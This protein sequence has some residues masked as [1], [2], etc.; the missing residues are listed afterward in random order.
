MKAL[1]F[2][3]TSVEDKDFLREIQ[4]LGDQFFIDFHDFLVEICG[5]SGDELAS[6]YTCDNDWVVQSEIS[7]IDMSIDD[8]DDDNEVGHDYKK[9]SKFY[10]DYSEDDLEDE[11]DFEDDLEDEFDDINDLELDEVNIK[12]TKH[13]KE[14][15]KQDDEFEDTDFNVNLP[16]KLMENTYIGGIVKKVG[17]KLLYQYDFFAPVVLNI[18]CTKIEETESDEYPI[19]LDEVGILE[20]VSNPEYRNNK[21]F[22][23][24][25]SLYSESEGVKFESL[26]DIDDLFKEFSDDFDDLIDDDDAL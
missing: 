11:F 8:E 3:I 14:S 9:A 18:E 5:F 23:Y 12:G 20:Y 26:D 10:S 7:L 24:M 21:K 16:M 17:Q 6:F 22:D 25:D 1:T 2:R 4:I 19:L 15:I 13:K